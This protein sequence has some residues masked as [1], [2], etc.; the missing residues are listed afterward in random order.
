MQTNLLSGRSSLILGFYAVISIVIIAVKCSIYGRVFSP[1]FF[2]IVLFT[3]IF[4]VAIHNGEISF[5]SLF[6][7]LACLISLLFNEINPLFR[8]EERFLLFL[9]LFM[10]FGPL[11]LSDETNRFRYL[12]FCGVNNLFVVI[13]IISFISFLF[14]RGYVRAGFGGIAGHPMDLAPIVALSLIYMIHRIKSAKKWQKRLI[15]LYLLI[16]IFTLFLA[17]S[18]GAI[19]GFFIAA[20]YLII[21]KKSSVKQTILNIC[22]LVIVPLALVL[23]NPMN[24][25]T[26]LEDKFERVEETDDMYG[27]REQKMINRMAE[28]RE[29]PIIGIG[30]S[31]MHTLEMDSK[32][33]FEPSNGWM[34]ILSSTGFLGFIFAVL[35]FAIPFYKYRKNTKLTFLLSTTLFFIIHTFIEG[36]SLT[37]GNPLCILMWM[38]VALINK[39]ID[40]Y[41]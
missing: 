21:K 33:H 37:V 3:P 39:P 28:F 10:G 12:V 24:V 36:Y 19:V 5:L 7:L 2:F 35:L 26:N 29:S 4:I 22:A 16:G 9:V 30:F 17:A 18:R 1:L 13:T 6:F 41:E 15:I 27:G 14:G 25:M 38:N 31:S 11:F 40:A 32:G 8:A 20:L 23:V 34:F